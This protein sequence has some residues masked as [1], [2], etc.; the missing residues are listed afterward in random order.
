MRHGRY[1]NHAKFS[2]LLSTIICTKLCEEG[3]FNTLLHN[4]AMLLAGLVFHR[5]RRAQDFE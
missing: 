3:N 2:A 5:Q 1:R 4:M